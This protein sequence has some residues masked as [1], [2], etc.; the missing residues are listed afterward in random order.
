MKTSMPPQSAT[1]K[2]PPAPWAARSG[3]DTFGAY[4]DLELKGQTQRF[5]WCP[6]GRFV[7]GS[8]EN[9]NQRNV[10]LTRGFWMADT[11]V[12]QGLYAAV[13]G[14]NPSK[15][16]FAFSVDLPVEMVSWNDA[17]EMVQAVNRL[18]RSYSFRLPTEAEWEY[19]ARAGTTGERYGPVEEIAWT[20]ENSLQRPHSVG[21]KRP[22]PWGL[23]DTLGNVWEWVQDRYDYNYP[24]GELLD[25]KGPDSGPFRVYRG[26]SWYV[27]PRGAR[28]AYRDRYTPGTRYDH[29]GLRLVR[30]G[31]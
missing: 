9:G 2:A 15:F 1:T 14:R 26:G 29:L 7:M 12:T 5:R 30:T 24:P 18:T 19:A 3:Q 11:P 13:M 10:T 27:D 4:A 23:Y 31:P 8:P 6:P 17:Q 22:N 20:A 28:V 25:P 16:R 21:Q